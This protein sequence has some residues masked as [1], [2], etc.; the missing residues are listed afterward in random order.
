LRPSFYVWL[1]LKPRPFIKL[2]EH[3]ISDSATGYSRSVHLLRGPA[4]QEQ[5]LCLFLDGEL[6]LKEMKI[7]AVLD[8]LCQRS[9]LPPVSFAFIDHLNMKARGEDYTC[10]D[11]FGRFIGEKVIPWLQQEIGG[12]RPGHH[13]IGG[14]SLS[15]LASVWLALQYPGHFRY[16]LSQSGSFWWNDQHLAKMAVQRA[17]IKTRFWLSVGDQETEVDEPPEVS[18]I[19]GVKNAHQVLKSLGAIVHYN[20]YH[21]GHDPKYWRAEFSQALHWLLSG[22]QD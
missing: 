9:A 6:Y 7:A 3:I 19:E 17:S 1:E 11:R 22:N 18:Q 2:E 16:C 13:L 20:E 4:D 21:G 8:D 10:N 5:R 12:L 14:L 15:G